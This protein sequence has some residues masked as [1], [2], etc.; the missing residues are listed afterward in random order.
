MTIVLLLALIKSLFFLRIFDSLSYLVTLLRSVIYDLRIFMLF[1]GILMF[2]FSL[3]I[4][5]LGLS[6]FSATP[7][8]VEGIAKTS[9]PGIEY[10]HIGLFLGNMIHVVRISIGDNDFSGSI[11]LSESLNQLFWIVWVIIVFIMCII[12][13]NFIIAEASASYEKVSSNITYFL[14]LQKVNLI[15]ESEEM[16]PRGMRTEERFPKYIVSRD[17]ED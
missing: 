2:M 16:M 9:L 4:G 1:Y 7:E 12:F 15:Y 17:K 10:Q 13:L 14:L 6:N 3:I 11:F 8:L 5:V